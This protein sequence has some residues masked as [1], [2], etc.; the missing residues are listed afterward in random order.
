MKENLDQKVEIFGLCY[1]KHSPPKSD[2]KAEIEQK[3]ET[4]FSEES[5]IATRE[6]FHQLRW[7]KLLHERS[8]EKFNSSQS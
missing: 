3:K 7:R 6:S 1:L 5:R 4:T 2:L 8:K